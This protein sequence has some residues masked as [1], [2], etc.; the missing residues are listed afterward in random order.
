[1][2]EKPDP[3]TNVISLLSGGDVSKNICEGL[4]SFIVT[5][6]PIPWE[7]AKGRIGGNPI[8][9]VFVDSMER[10]RVEQQLEELPEFECVVAIGGGQ[11]IDLGKYFSW[12]RKARLIT[13]PSVISVDAF[14]T[15]AA[16]IRINRKVEYIGKSSPD[17]L[18]ID[19]DLIRTA[20]V[21][22]N[23]AGVG[24]LLSIHTAVYD[25][26]IA[27][28]NGENQYQLHQK[29]VDQAYKILNSIIDHSEDIRNLTNKGIEAIVK[30]YMEVNRVCLPEGHYRIEEGSEHYLFYELEERTGRAYIHGHIIGLGIYIMSHLQKNKHERIVALMDKM[31][32]KYQPKD[33]KIKP[34]TLID[35]LHNLQNYVSERKD[36]WYT[37]ID[38]EAITSEWISCV[39]SELEF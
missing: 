10:E 36:L 35:S 7:L 39:T 28:K 3:T 23:I 14:V 33:M 26:E 2:I 5:T 29:T 20:P 22:L 9:I 16:A 27:A 37:V 1:M 21:D 15:P 34:Q 38:Q 25:W 30:G 11:A 24:D 8:R 19:Y 12:K 13:I 31:R 32:L 4:K 17:P 6:M 18:V